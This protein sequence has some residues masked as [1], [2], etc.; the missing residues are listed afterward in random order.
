MPFIVACERSW[1][2]QIYRRWAHTYGQGNNSIQIWC[3]HFLTTIIQLMNLNIYLYFPI[4]WASSWP[5]KTFTFVFQWPLHFNREVQWNCLH[6]DDLHI[7]IRNEI[8]RSTFFYGGIFRYM[9]D[10]YRF[11]MWRKLFQIFWDFTILECTISVTN[12]F[13][14]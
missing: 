11:E 5:C 12:Y 1:N 8:L 7:Q 4:S 9:H 13:P 6:K 14:Y 3:N 2:P 10:S